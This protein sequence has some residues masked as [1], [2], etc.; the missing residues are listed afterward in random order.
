MGFDHIELLAC[1]EKGIVVVNVP[2]YG[3]HTV[4]EHT[5]P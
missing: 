1:K 4:A 2:T 5:L 3:A